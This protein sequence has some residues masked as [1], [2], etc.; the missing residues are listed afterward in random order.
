MS[1]QETS[2]QVEVP[3]GAGHEGHEQPSVLSVS[4]QLM[5]L[6]WITFG[7]MLFVLYK[8][9][10]KPILAGL[11]KRE[12]DLRKAVDDAARIRDELAAMDEKRRAIIAQADGQAKQ[13]VDA[14]R[15]AA[16]DAATVIEN[17]AREEAQILVENAQ[18]EIRAAHEKAVTSLRRESADLA[19]DLARRVIRDN[20]DEARSR[21]LTDQLIQNI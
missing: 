9:A 8:K 19:I 21:K 6:T 12:A 10:W 14:A 2:A 16:T 4:P 13:I 7:L 5:G 1:E 18:R 17:K 15:Q 20:L 11:D 3:A